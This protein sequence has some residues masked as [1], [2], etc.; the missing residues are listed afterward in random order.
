VWRAA[1]TA[2]SAVKKAMA[3]ALEESVT[4]QLI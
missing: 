2:L 4:A 1:D 3:L